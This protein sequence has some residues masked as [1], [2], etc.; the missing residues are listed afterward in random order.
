MTARRRRLL[1]IWSLGGDGVGLGRAVERAL[2]PLTLAAAM[3]TQQV[4]HAQAVGGEARQVGLDAHG[5]RMPPSTDTLPDAPA[6]SSGAGAIMGVGE[7]GEITQGDGW[8]R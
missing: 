7:I 1:E 6:P 8:A 5:R 4:G 3:A 2:G